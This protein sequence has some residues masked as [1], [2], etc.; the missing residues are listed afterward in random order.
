MPAR[1]IAAEW[2]MVDERALELKMRALM[3]GS[4]LACLEAMPAVIQDL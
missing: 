3:P 4:A 1:D 2:R